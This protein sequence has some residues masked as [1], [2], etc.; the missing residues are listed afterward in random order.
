MSRSNH[1]KHR[2]R[3]WKADLK[4]IGNARL[5]VRVKHFLK[6]VELEPYT[7]PPL[8]KEA[9]NPWSFD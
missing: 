4:S 3:K 6:A 2:Y 8:V 1:Q 7:P 9:G 5:R